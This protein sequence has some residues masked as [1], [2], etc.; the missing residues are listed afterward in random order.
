MVFPRNAPGN[1]Q[2]CPYLFLIVNFKIV[3]HLFLNSLAPGG[4]L[5]LGNKENIQFSSWANHFLLSVPA[6]K[7]FKKLY[8]SPIPLKNP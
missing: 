5:C 7:I 1:L 8:S 3:I 4:V 2:K 6:E